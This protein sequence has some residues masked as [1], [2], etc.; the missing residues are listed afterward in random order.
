MYVSG[1]L[2]CTYPENRSVC[3]REMESRCGLKK[4]DLNRLKDS[5]TW[6]P[7]NETIW[8]GLGGM[9][10]LEGVCPGGLPQFS[11]SSLCLLHVGQAE[12]LAI[13]A[14][15]PLLLSMTLAL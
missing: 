11:I 15:R 7:V 9:V 4:N 14:S 1:K 3:P 5:N 12:L 6:I 8:E 10:L 2:K 13:P